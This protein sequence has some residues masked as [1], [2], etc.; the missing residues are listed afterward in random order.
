MT[1]K[2]ELLFHDWMSSLT[3]ADVQHETFRGKHHR[4]LLRAQEQRRRMFYGDTQERLVGL[5]IEEVAEQFLTVGVREPS[6]QP[7]ADR[8]RKNGRDTLHRVR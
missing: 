8:R 6:Q 7:L 1:I 4:Q 5:T 3:L 2:D